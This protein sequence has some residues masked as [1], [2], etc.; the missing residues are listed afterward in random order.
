MTSR[1]GTGK[2]LTFFYSVGY[3]N[4]CPLRPN[5]DPPTPPGTHWGG[6]TRL[7]VRGWESHF[8]P[9]EKKPSTLSTLSAGR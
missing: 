4:V 9:L 5:W 6:H 7:L 2:L 3:Q 8:G 1:L